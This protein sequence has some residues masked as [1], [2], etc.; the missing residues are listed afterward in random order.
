MNLDSLRSAADLSPADRAVVDALPAGYETNATGPAAAQRALLK[1]WFPWLRDE[2][3]DVEGAATVDTL[4]EWFASLDEGVS[5][6]PPLSY[7]EKQWAW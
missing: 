1:Q 3:E 2:D 5:T 7:A 6:Y 4:N